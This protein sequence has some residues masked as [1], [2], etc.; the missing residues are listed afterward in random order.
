MKNIKQIN[1]KNRTYYFF[2]DMINLK[3]FAPSLIKINN[4]LCK[5][6]GFYH[7]GQ[8]TIKIISDCENINSVNQL[9]LIVGDV[10]GYIEESNRKKYLTF[11]S[12]LKTKRY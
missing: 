11:A 12:S 4:K 6:I 2:K 5:N 8:I 3:T 10:D 7:L 9:Y 1:I